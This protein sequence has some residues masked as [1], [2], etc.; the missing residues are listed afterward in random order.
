MRTLAVTLSLSVIGVAPLS[1]QPLQ[2]YLLKAVSSDGLT[3]QRL[4]EVLVYHADVPDAVL[5]PN[6]QVCVY[7]QGLWT[8][9]HDGIMVGISPDGL[10]NW[11]FDQVPIVGTEGWPGRPC[12]PDIIVTGNAFRLYFTGDPT[13]DMK[14][15]TYSAVSTDGIHFTREAGVRFAVAGSQ[16]LDPSLLWTGGTLQYFAGGAAPGQ[17]WHAHSSDGLTI[18]QQAN[19]SA[20]GLMMANGLALPGSGYRFYGFPN[21]PRGGIRSLYSDDGESWTVEPGWRL[22]LDVS[23]GLESVYVK[24][25]AVVYKD[26]TYYMFYVTRIPVHPGDMNC[27][28]AVNFDDINPLV[29]ALSNFN[30]YIAAYPACNVFN[31]D[32]DHDGD[33]DFDD[34]NAFVALLGRGP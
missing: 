20:E 17:N 23:N 33:V 26:N 21:T 29:L 12:D 18:V 13:G 5:G 3:W 11:T 25:S 34:I 14:P 32:C 16:V 30:G 6:G 31:A 4:N 19:F 9:I 22:Q 7:F 15:E 27:D 2:N 8:P 28:G 10:G 24:D 1:A